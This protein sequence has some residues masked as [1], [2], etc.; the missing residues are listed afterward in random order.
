LAS[1]RTIIRHCQLAATDKRIGSRDLIVDVVKSNAL[2]AAIN[3]AGIVR[4]IANNTFLH[5]VLL[6]VVHVKNPPRQRQYIYTYTSHT[7]ICGDVIYASDN[8]CLSCRNS[9]KRHSTD[10][11]QN[12]FVKR[13]LATVEVSHVKTRT[14]VIVKFRR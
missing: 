8:H 2:P 11:A 14:Y 7:C 6:L 1:Y 10:S 5:G 9:T 3:Q 12:Q 4:H 13:A